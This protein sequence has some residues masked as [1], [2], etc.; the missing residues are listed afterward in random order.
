MT[1]H[2]QH[3]SY[4]HHHTSYNP[5][6]PYTI[7]NHANTHTHTQTKKQR[8]RPNR[9][10]RQHLTPSSSSSS[11]SS[12]SNRCFTWLL[13]PRQS[14]THIAKNRS[15]FSSYRRA[16]CKIANQRVLGV[17]TVQLRVQRAPDDPRTNTLVLHDVLHMPNARCNGIS[18][19]KYTG[20]S[21]EETASE[22][23]SSAG[24]RAV[25]EE[26]EN[27]G[28][29]KVKSEREDGEGLWFARGRNTN[30][31]GGDGGGDDG[32]RVVLA[33]ERKDY[34]SGGG[35]GDAGA[36]RGIMGVVASKEELEMLSERV[37]NRSWV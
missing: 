13:L 16:P 17:G 14:N 8:S 23:G 10:Q 35:E 22:G 6:H 33:G 9:R 4:P 20:E 25:V 2:L 32:L 31:E 5:Y 26:V 1:T 36:G 11:K 21:E 28:V 27:G 34:G 18:V 12:N 19:S 3:P 7:P 30:N 37:R 29:V 15:S 24:E